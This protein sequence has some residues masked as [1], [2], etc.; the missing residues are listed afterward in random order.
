[1]Y[2]FCGTH[3]MNKID[4]KGTEDTAKV[5]SNANYLLLTLSCYEVMPEKIF[6]ANFQ[7]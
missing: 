6:I 2:D 7:I 5:R 4:A 1:M 3:F